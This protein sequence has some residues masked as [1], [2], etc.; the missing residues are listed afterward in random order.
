MVVYGY[1]NHIM[2]TLIFSLSF[3]FHW[4]LRTP[5]PS[6]T[7]PPPLQPFVLFPLACPPSATHGHRPSPRRHRPCPSRLHRRCRTV[8][9]TDRSFV[10][11]L[12]V[13]L[14]ELNVFRVGHDE[15]EGER[16]QLLERC[17][18][19]LPLLIKVRSCK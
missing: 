13:Y 14:L 7:A 3:L 17:L 10:E 8:S 2:F 6:L 4:L 1:T 12:H 18:H 11:D 5:T 16:V 19:P 15:L 9:P